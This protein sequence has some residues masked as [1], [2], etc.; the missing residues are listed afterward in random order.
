[1]ARS[2]DEGSES[3]DAPASTLDD[4]LPPLHHL[5]YQESKPTAAGDGLNLVPGVNTDQITIIA[6]LDRSN[7]LTEARWVKT[8]DIEAWINQLGL[9][10]GVTTDWQGKIIVTDP[11]PVNYFASSSSFTFAVG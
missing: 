1:M 6:Y 3:V 7:P 8:G 5:I 9:S 2:L 11:D 4:L 10:S